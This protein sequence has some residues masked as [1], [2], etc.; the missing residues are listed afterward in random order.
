M[1]LHKNVMGLEHPLYLRFRNAGE[2]L[3]KLVYCPAVLE[4]KKCSN[5]HL[6]TF[7]GPSTADFLRVAFYFGAA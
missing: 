3:E 2:R 4:F 1:Y 6:K 5:R 7:E